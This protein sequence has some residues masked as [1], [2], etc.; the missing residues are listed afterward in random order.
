MV[1][2]LLISYPV[3]LQN[4]TPAEATAAWII[5]GGSLIAYFSWL[6]LYLQLS[7]HAGA[8]KE[9][10]IFC[11]ISAFI[12]GINAF[13]IPWA[14]IS[15]IGYVHKAQDNYHRV[16]LLNS[17]S[18]IRIL[19]VPILVLYLF[20]GTLGAILSRSIIRQ[21]HDFDMMLSIGV[22]A[23]SV[24]IIFLIYLVHFSMFVGKIHNYKKRHRK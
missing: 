20:W 5:I 17:G 14:L 13:W 21:L 1:M 9:R 12:P 15:S 23:V 10:L 19:T 22:I 8:S 2:N 3:F 11:L 4:I 16:N 7:K 6:Y 24:L 18:G